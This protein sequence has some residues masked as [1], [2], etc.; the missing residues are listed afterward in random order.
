MPVIWRAKLAWMA[1]DIF[2]ERLNFISKMIKQH[3]I[4]ILMTVDNCLAHPNLETRQ[5]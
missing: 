5:T 2:T 3:N 4:K 1:C